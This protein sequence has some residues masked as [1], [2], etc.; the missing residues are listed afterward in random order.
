MEEVEED[1]HQLEVEEASCLPVVE[2]AYHE[3]EEEALDDH[4][5]VEEVHL[6]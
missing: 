6:G 4:L 1:D 3:L 5:P 2:E